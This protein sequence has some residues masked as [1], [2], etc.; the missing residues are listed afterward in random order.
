M[1][2][3]LI[4]RSLNNQTN[5]PILLGHN[6]DENPNRLWQ[7]PDI[8]WENHPKI[9]AGLDE[10]NGKKGSWL[11]VNRDGVF[12]TLLNQSGTIGHKVSNHSRGELVIEALSCRSA[13]EA[14][15]SLK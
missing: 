1:C 10:N 14:K 13:E 11:G 15:T 12:C 9:I 8:H 5:W 4:Y 6:R 2:K 3:L 7:K